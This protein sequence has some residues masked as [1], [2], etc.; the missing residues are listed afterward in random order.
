MI[1]KHGLPAHGG[2]MS[3]THHR[4]AVVAAALPLLLAMAACDSDAM[5]GAKSAGAQPP[6]G[7]A[8]ASVV[9]KP[10]AFTTK[11]LAGL[12]ITAADLPA[13][14]STGGAGET[15]EYTLGEPDNAACRQVVDLIDS[16]S[17]TIEPTGEASLVIKKGGKD[18]EGWTVDAA[19][20]SG[21][22]AADLIAGFA[23][24]VPGCQGFSAVDSEGDTATYRVAVAPSPALGDE[25]VQF[26]YNVDYSS[27]G[28]AQVVMTAVRT[29]NVL[30]EF[31]TFDALGVPEEIPSDLVKKQVDLVIQAVKA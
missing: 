27:G 13:G 6:S 29:G 15:D 22:G 24:A 3:F 9:P 26:T 8:P 17:A 11:Q 4:I 1:L 23:K 5:A 25:A 16:R 19:G 14:R 20:Y 21:D 7:S 31:V 2:I 18:T 10:K 28:S 12:L 30:I